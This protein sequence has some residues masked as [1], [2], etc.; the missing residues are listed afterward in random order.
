MCK[1]PIL[2]P[3]RCCKS[4][5]G[6]S[7][8]DIV[9]DVPVQLTSEE[10]ERSLKHFGTLLT[11]KTSQILRRDEPN[12]TSMYNSAYNY[13]ATGRFTF[14]RKNLY[15]SFYLSTSTPRPRSIQFIDGSGSILEEQ[16][17]DPIG[18]VYQNATGK[19]C[20]VW[21]RVPRDYRKLLRDERL[22]VSFIWEPSATLTG[23]L[24]R[25]RALSTEQYSSLLEPTMGVDRSL[26][27]GAGATAIVSAS[28]ASAPS[29]HV[30]LV[31]NGV[32]FA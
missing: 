7:S 28:S 31:F 27:S 18:G 16:T 4:C 12:P 23:Q 25:Y 3:D 15:Y 6:N 13:L 26:M 9:Q 10:E 30:S 11:G 21:R 24:S 5:P 20:G 32:F 14:H 1:D 29:I 8:T 22:H 2:L 19:L 17:I